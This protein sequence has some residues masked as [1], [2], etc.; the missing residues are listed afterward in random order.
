V[1][2]AIG[3]HIAEDIA[4]GSAHRA[5]IPHALSNAETTARLKQYHRHLTGDTLKCLQQS[6]E[7]G[8]LTVEWVRDAKVVRIMGKAV[9]VGEDNLEV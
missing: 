6:R 9:Q 2:N 4:T 3:N 8:E 7:G 1:I 5:I